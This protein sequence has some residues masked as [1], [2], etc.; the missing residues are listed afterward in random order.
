MMNIKASHSER[1]P[2]APPRVTVYGTV[3]ELTLKNGGTTGKNDGGS[4]PDKTGF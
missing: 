2:Y 3:R 1:L 4:G